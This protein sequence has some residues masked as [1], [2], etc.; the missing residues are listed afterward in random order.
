MLKEL[1]D[2]LMAEKPEGASH[3]ADDCPYCKSDADPKEA[4]EVSVSYTEE[5]LKAKVDEAV[6]SATKEL[7]A[8]VKEL[9][10]VR[11]ASEV[12]AKLAEAKAEFETKVSEIQAQLDT[13]VLEAE[14]AKTEK[15]EIVAFLEAEG[16]KAEEAAA[17]AARRDE[18][19]KQVAEVA[20]FPEEYVEA[21]ADRWAGL[22]D[23][24]FAALLEDYKAVGAKK[25]DEGSDTAPPAGSAMTASRENKG[26][27][28]VM[29]EV[30]RGF[31]TANIDPRTL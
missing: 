11:S 14:K 23:E 2:L 6:S 28:K 13:A 24:Q 16:K 22:D 3:P 5:E 1:H 8:K 21:N 20:S 25:D 26:D 7:E 10:E 9:E 29:S 19:L 15:E 27:A 4:E 12:E 31:R 17:L 30:I 18:R